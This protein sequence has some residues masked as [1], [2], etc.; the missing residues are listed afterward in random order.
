MGR[1][2][3]HP[4]ND[5]RGLPKADLE[6]TLEKQFSSILTLIQQKIADPEDAADLRQTV[7]EQALLSRGGYDGRQTPEN[8]LAGITFHVTNTH[9]SNVYRNRQRNCE[10]D[11][12][13]IDAAYSFPSPEDEIIERLDNA[14]AVNGL[15]AHVSERQRQAIESRYLLD[16]HR[17]E[18]AEKMGRS[19]DT[20]N[21]YIHDGISTM[22]QFGWAETV[23]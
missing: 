20:V 15:M 7:C 22:R 6:Y 23:D 18:I 13:V 16:M 8:W 19:P 9:L 21:Q 5:I 12:G 10:I 4:D 3:P 17:N 11:L 14:A 1:T 2:N